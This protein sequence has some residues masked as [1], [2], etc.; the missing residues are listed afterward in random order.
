[1]PSGIYEMAQKRPVSCTYRLKNVPF[2]TS[3]Y[4]TKYTPKTF[5][6]EYINFL[7][8]CYLRRYGVIPVKSFES[9]IGPQLPD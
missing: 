4:L 5:F 6:K 7:K 2:F 8:I 9:H 1:M 3:K